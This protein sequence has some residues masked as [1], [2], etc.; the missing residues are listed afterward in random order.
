MKKDKGEK[1]TLNYHMGEKDHREF[2]RIHRLIKQRFGSIEKI[3]PAFY[4]DMLHGEESKGFEGLK[5]YI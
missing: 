4:M 5:K 1:K 3:I 2:K